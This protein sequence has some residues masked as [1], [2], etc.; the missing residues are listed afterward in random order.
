MGNDSSKGG[1]GGQSP[2]EKTETK[3]Q[4]IFEKIIHN[5]KPASS[6]DK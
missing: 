6:K 4:N 3:S 2:A 5:A 1:G